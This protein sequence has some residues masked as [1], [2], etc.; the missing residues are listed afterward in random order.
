MAGARTSQRKWQTEN[1]DEERPCRW[2]GHLQGIEDRKLEQ[3]I[4]SAL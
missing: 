4:Q 2:R 3:E 1:G